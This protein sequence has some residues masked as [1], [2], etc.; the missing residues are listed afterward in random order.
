MIKRLLQYVGMVVLR[1][2]E[3]Q[4]SKEGGVRRFFGHNDRRGA[5]STCCRCLMYVYVGN[6]TVKVFV[7][8]SRTRGTEEKDGGGR[9]LQN[10]D[11]RYR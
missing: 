6:R 3:S 2:K 8:Q 10:D 9:I 4:L 5:D 11:P 1:S 7:R